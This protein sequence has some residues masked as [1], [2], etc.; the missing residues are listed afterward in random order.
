M[1]IYFFSKEC[2]G[3]SGDRLFSAEQRP[4]PEALTDHCSVDDGYLASAASQPLLDLKAHRSRAEHMRHVADPEGAGSGQSSLGAEVPTTM[5]ANTCADA[6]TDANSGPPVPPT[7]CTITANACP[8]HEDSSPSDSSLPP[9]ATPSHIKKKRRN[10]KPQPRWKVVTTYVCLATV[11]VVLTAACQDTDLWSS[12]DG[13][14]SVANTT[15]ST[16]IP[17]S[18]MSTPRTHRCCLPSCCL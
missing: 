17:P 6:T 13:N 14:G 8:N 5:I 9:N 3:L 1:I 12:A 16:V 4:E 18:S 7:S 15:A 10:R 2:C 11:A